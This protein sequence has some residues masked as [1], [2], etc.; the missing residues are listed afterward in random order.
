MGEDRFKQ[1]MIIKLS[2]LTFFIDEGESVPP[3]TSLPIRHR[4]Y[5]K[6]CNTCC[7]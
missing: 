7:L 5:P 6:R 3:H 1:G 2:N 4:P